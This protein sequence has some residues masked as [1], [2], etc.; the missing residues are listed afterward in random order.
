[1]RRSIYNIISVLFSGVRFA[2]MKIFYVNRFSWRGMERFSPNTEIHISENGSIHLGNRVRMHRRSKLS[3]FGNGVLEIGDN[4]AIGRDVSINCMDRITIGADVQLAEGTRIYDHDHDFRCPGGLK[5]EKYLT[6][7]VEIGDNCWIGCNV[8]ILRGT[9]L[10]KGCIV[11]AGSVLKGIYPD[12]SLVI[13]KRSTEII[14]C[15]QE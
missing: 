5:A 14:H 7:A 2:C 13:Q 9:K 11:G 8:I 15:A 12:N 1:M 4:T 6:A 10:G 3:A